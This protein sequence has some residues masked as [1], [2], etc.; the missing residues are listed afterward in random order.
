ME[1]IKD[2]NKLIIKKVIMIIF[3]ILFISFTTVVW[4]NKNAKDLL[5]AL[6]AVDNLNYTSFYIK[7]PIQ[8]NMYPMEDN[9]ALDNLEPCTLIVDNETYSKEVYKLVLKIDKESTIDYRYLH[10]SVFN[11]IYALSELE[12]LDNK[13]EYV[14]VFMRDSVVADTKYYDVRLWLNTL[15]GND[16]QNKELKMKFDFIN[17]TTKA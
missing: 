12:R 10:I 3:V 8:Y 17:E 4:H 14:F 2:I 7:N 6:K 13:N 9:Y 5:A 15:A 11:N 1:L 16:L